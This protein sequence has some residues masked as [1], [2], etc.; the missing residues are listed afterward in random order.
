MQK[1]N[2]KIKYLEKIFVHINFSVKKKNIKKFSQR[3]VQMDTSD[4]NCRF[5][6]VT[7]MFP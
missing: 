1:R 5:A 6:V 3:I 7:N 2:I 4:R